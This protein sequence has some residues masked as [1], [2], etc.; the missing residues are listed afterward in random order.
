MFPGIRNRYINISTVAMITAAALSF[1]LYAEEPQT[2]QPDPAE[3]AETKTAEE[4]S[5]SKRR[6]TIKR[7]DEL[8]YGF[9]RGSSSFSFAFG[10]TLSPTGS[11]VKH[12]KKYDDALRYRIENKQ[13]T[14]TIFQT[15]AV[16]F[17][18]V[19]KNG[20]SFIFDYEYGLTDY[21]GIG[22][23]AQYGDVPSE[24]QDVFPTIT[25]NQG[26]LVDVFP[27]DRTLYQGTMAG[28]L[29][30]FHPLPESRLDPYI[31]LRAGFVGFTGYAHEQ[32]YPDPYRFDYK[33]PNGLGSGF[34]IGAGLNFYAT[35][36]TGFK[37][38]GS[39]TRQMLKSDLFS[40]RSL[41]LYHVNFGMIFHTGNMSRL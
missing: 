38:E 5:E 12:E 28:L 6:E 2:E 25:A 15:P 26:E 22:F 31:V 4:K 24:R 11:Y 34:S 8:S 35:K 39:Y 7:I 33:V 16:Y 21:F 14:Q 36:F 20:G 23:S 9:Y 29:L 37:F 1:S 19:Y 18:S 40:G 30:S 13:V 17:Q 3:T 27:K 41:N 10:A 32:L